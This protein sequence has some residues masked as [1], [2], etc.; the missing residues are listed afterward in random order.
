MYAT[1]EGGGE[2]MNTQ[3]CD[4]KIGEVQWLPAPQSISRAQAKTTSVPE[5]GREVWKASFTRVK[6]TEVQNTGFP[7]LYD[8]FLEWSTLV[9]K[10]TIWEWEYGCLYC[11]EGWETQGRLVTA[12]PPGVC[13]PQ[14]THRLN[15]ATFKYQTL[16]TEL[17]TWAVLHKSGGL[18][19][20]AFSLCSSLWHHFLLSHQLTLLTY[21]TFHPH[22]LGQASKY[23]EA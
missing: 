8:M 12:C 21:I 17:H 19:T 20:W 23:S 15:W 13:C 1:E 2:R 7:S 6:G 14:A 5:G 11:V 18:P 22:P 9:P 4:R 10:V 16:L 3:T